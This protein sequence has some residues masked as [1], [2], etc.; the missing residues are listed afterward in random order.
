MSRRLEQLGGT[1]VVVAALLLAIVELALR[2]TGGDGPQHASTTIVN[3]VNIA[4][5]SV[6]MIGGLLLVVGLPVL[7][8]LL[9]SRAPV[10]AIGAFVLL[11]W[12]I[13]VYDVIIHF[14]DSVVLPY[15]VANNFTMLG[16][17][18]RGI[19]VTTITA[20]FAQI[21]GSALLGAACL[22][23]RLVPRVAGG[24]FIASALLMLGTLAHLP[25]LLDSLATFAL[26]GGLVIAGGR[27]VIG[28]SLDRVAEGHVQRRAGVR[29]A[30]SPVP[31]ARRVL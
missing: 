13:L 18:P 14:T 23:T 22:R 11:I 4:G 16:H 1:A 25:D 19:L 28:G 20:G 24:L 7:V 17:P 2:F 8:A 29:T 9:A 5:H 30:E 31:A 26:M 21:I 27:L 10:L 15:L 3:P 12:S 6:G